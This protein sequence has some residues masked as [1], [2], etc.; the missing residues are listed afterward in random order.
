MSLFNKNTKAKTVTTNHVGAKAYAHTAEYRLVSMLL[1]S[2]VQESYYRAANDGAKEM[3]ALLGE[4][5]PYFAAQAAVYAR[6]EFGMRSVTHLLAAAL[7][8]K[9]SGTD[10]GRRFFDRI[11]RR[12]DDML[13]ITAAYRAL[14]KGSNLTNAMKKGFA[15]AFDR[16]DGY[17]LAKYRAGTKAIKLID[18]VNLVRPVPTQRNATALQQLVE[19]TLRNVDTWEAKL[20]QA[21]TQVQGEDKEQAKTE[22]WAEMIREGKLGYMALL[23]NLRNLLQAGLQDAEFTQVIAQLTDERAIRKSLQFPFRF[24][25]AYAEIEPLLEEKPLKETG[26]TAI[27]F[28]KLASLM[29]AETEDAVAQVNERFQTRVMEVLD[30]LEKAVNVSVANLPVLSGKTAVLTDNSGSMRGDAGGAS[31]VSALSKRTTADIANLF[32][33]LCAQRYAQT[34]IGLFGDRLIDGEITSDSVFANFKHV[35][36]Q[37]LACGPGTETGIFDFFKRIIKARQIIDRVVIFSDMQIGNRCS[38]FTTGGQRGT[39]F[40]KLY[41][42]YREINPD[43]RVYS[44]DLRGYGTTV[45]K[46]GEYKIAG[47][48]DK[49]FEIMDRC[50]Q[51]PQAL[52]TTIRQYDL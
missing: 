37:A 40:M 20:S 27:P 36:K 47:W 38:W 4:V 25:S 12:P 39:D 8:E 13:E 50:E 28:R 52:L 24:L 26:A 18:M 46:E 2:F 41:E 1:T 7:A 34:Y 9:A 6:R 31:A 43:V 29:G 44:I 48:S 19:G 51:D 5:D 45:F 21:G 32:A 35:N 17:Q 22:A 10:W 49:I 42:Q 11:V 30:G 16:F 3:I 23:R 14:N 33:V 15:A